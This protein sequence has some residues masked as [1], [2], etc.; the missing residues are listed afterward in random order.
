MFF[1]FFKPK[2]FKIWCNWTAKNCPYYELKEETKRKVFKGF[3]NRFFIEAFKIH[4]SSF[5]LS[6]VWKKVKKDFNQLVKKTDLKI[7]SKT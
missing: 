4:L 1:K 2:Q 6:I 5:S 3:K 7:Q